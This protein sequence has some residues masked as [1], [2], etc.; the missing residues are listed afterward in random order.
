MGDGSGISW[1]ICKQ[2]APRSRQTTTPTLHHSIFTGWMLF[3][4]PNQ[5]CQSTEG[6]LPVNQNKIYLRNM[7]SV[8]GVVAMS[9]QSTT[10][11]SSLSLAGQCIF[12]YKY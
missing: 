6:T 11:C 4:M 1:T 10:S 2:S 12:A 5:Q 7:S 9:K 3:L 8:L